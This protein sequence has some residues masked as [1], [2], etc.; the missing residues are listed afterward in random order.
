MEI[1]ESPNSTMKK[2]PYCAE[3]I[4]FE[5]IICRYCGHDLTATIQ[6]EVKPSSDGISNSARL[7]AGVGAVGL[8][9]GAILPWATM[10]APFVGTVSIYGYEGDGLISGG[11]GLVMLIVVLAS[12]GKT[13]KIYSIVGIIFSIIAF[14][15]LV[16][17]LSNISDVIDQSDSLIG[18]VGPGIYISIIGSFI[19]FV[20]SIMKSK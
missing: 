15:V 16:P 4:Q 11:I 12:K 9:V 18:S 13:G 10:S 3:E 19:L 17:K 5:A 20:G 8:L 6:P 14:L 1:S 7:L 2:C